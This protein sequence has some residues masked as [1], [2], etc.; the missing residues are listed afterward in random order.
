MTVKAQSQTDGSGPEYRHKGIFAIGL[1]LANC[2]H[3][4][5]EI[6]TASPLQQMGILPL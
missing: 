1:L 6:H 4:T 3:S 5:G 2:C